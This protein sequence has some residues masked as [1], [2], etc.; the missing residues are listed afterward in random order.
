MAC[1]RKR[2]EATTD[3]RET[4]RVAPG[5]S[6]A[7]RRRSSMPT[8]PAQLDAALLDATVA[9]KGSPTTSITIAASCRSS[10]LTAWLPAKRWRAVWG[11]ALRVGFGRLVLAGGAF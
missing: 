5:S 1:R 6:P 11:P 4:H 7:S 2:Y 8:Q 3:S 9:P 10:R